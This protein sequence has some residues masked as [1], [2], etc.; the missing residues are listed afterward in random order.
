VPARTTRRRRARGPLLLALVLVLA[1]IAGVAGWWFGLG[2]YTATP[3]VID[4]PQARAEQRIEQA[5]LSFRVG[6]R[7][8]SETVAKGSVVRTDPAPGSRILENGTVSAIISRGPERYAVPTLRGMSEDRA[9]QALADQHLA[10]GDAV[11]RFNGKVSAG[12]VLGTRPEAGTELKRDTAVDLVVSKGPR[13]ID[14]RDFTGKDVDKAT[15]WADRVGLV[16]QLTRQHDAKVPKD[17][18]ISQEP[19]EGELFKG[20]PVRF[21]VSDGPEMV[22][23]PDVKGVGIDEATARLE[24]AGFEVETEHADI[25][26]G[27]EYVV[28]SDPDQGSMAP[29]GSVVT[30]T[31]V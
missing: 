31:L 29:R 19:A 13:P 12:V 9:K 5:G 25:Y 17:T 4:L 15:R 16:P 18:V 1:A 11:R 22:Q 6:G 23:V 3:G 26:V 28:G 30:L 10:F 14:V 27:L 24:A 21:V 20:D 8:W 7:T 2:R